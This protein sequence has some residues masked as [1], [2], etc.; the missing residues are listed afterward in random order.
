MERK[1]DYDLLRKACADFLE[2]I[3]MFLPDENADFGKLDS[4]E[5]MTLRIMAEVGIS[6]YN[7]KK[8]LE[9]EEKS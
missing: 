5:R 6:V 1:D 3:E 9:N 7:L 2:Q 4:F 8:E